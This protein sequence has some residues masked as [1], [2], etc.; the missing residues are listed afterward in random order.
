MKHPFE[1]A[2]VV[3][4]RYISVRHVLSMMQEAL[5]FRAG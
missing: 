5:L 4:L 2:K 3:P 1:P